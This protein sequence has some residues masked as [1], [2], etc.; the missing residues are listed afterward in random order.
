VAAFSSLLKCT[1]TLAP[2]EENIS[3]IAFPIPREAP[4][5]RTTLSLNEISIE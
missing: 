5:T 4:V 2:E 3:A 1:I